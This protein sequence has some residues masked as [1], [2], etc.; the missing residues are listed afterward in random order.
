M[1]SYR[2]AM[3]GRISTT[4]VIPTY[5]GGSRV[6]MVLR[7]L[8]NG[9]LP[10]DTLEVIVLDNASAEDV[11]AIVSADPAWRELSAAGVRCRVVLEPT[12][13]LTTARLRGIREAAADIICFLDDDT[14]PCQGYIAAGV[15]AFD[16]PRVGMLTSRVFPRY[17]VQPSAA[18]AKREHMLAIN[19][20]LGDKPFDW[21]A[22][23]TVAGT[24]GAGMWIRRQAVAAALERC[25]ERRWL[26]DRTG[27]ALQSGGDIEMG[28]MV[29]AAGFRRL[30]LPTLRLDHH[31]PAGRVSMTYFK[32]L[33]ASV[34]RSQLTLTHR[35]PSRPWST[36]DR[37][38]ALARYCGA[39]LALPVLLLRKDGWREASLVLTAR[40]AEIDGPE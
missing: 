9:N 17:E 13:G 21:G 34:V 33:T 36:R 20:R 35:Y 39:L 10:Q 12:P 30:Y 31:I 6:V 29:G 8:A 19:H 15:A 14:I 22:T 40:R 32:R 37:V 7:A 23:A 4:I 25:D 24:I 28:V 11:R 2:D 5:N 27:A 26:P 16:D 18:I 3:S 38:R 1:P